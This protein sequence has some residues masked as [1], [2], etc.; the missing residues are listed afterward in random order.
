MTVSKARRSSGFLNG[1]TE[2]TDDG[3]YRYKYVRDGMFSKELIISKED[4][5]ECYN[6]W[7]KGVSNE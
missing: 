7:I 5:I 2:I 6:T 3:L 1:E 4:F